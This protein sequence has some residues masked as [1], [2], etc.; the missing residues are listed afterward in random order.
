MLLN[1]LLEAT[2]EATET[3]TEAATQANGIDWNALWNTIVQWCT[4]VGLKLL[5]GLIVLF[6]A[7]KITNLLTKK[8]YKHLQKRQADETLSRVGTQAIRILI[9]VILL[10]CF[11]GYIGIETASISALIASLGVGIGLAVQG[12][13]SNLAGG[14]IIIVMRPFRIGDTITT[15]GETG[16]VEDIHMFYTVLVTP[17]N[18]VVHV[19]NGS[20]ANNVI[21]NNSIK[22]TRRVDVVM[23]ISYD[24]DYDHAV[25]V[26][27]E[28]CSK[29]ALIFNEPAPFVGINAYSAS[30]VDL[31]IRVWCANKDYWTINKYLLVEI[32]KAFDEKGIEIPFNQLE[33]AIKN[34]EA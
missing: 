31:V 32:K 8:L 24:T 23:S 10:V 1:V 17:D 29:N 14:V 19:P 20:L 2:A 3:T 22:E 25:E 12:S 5:I 16:T 30:S 4:S 11:V 21:V 13:L 18:K 9:K 34:K 33:V 6:I 28:V 15:N 7:F 26:I 27:N